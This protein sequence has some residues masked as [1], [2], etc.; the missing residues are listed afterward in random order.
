VLAASVALVFIRRRRR[1]QGRVCC[2][3]AAAGG[4]GQAG[5]AAAVAGLLPSL[6]CCSPIMPTLAGLAGLPA[7]TRLEATGT[8]TYFFAARQD[9]LLGGALGLLAASGAWPVRKLARALQCHGLLRD[10]RPAS[11]RRRS[12]AGIAPW[13][14]SG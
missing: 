10:T 6:L 1:S 11:R 9:W 4:P 12:P 13:R 5:T 2:D 8:I 14:G 3:P 7:A